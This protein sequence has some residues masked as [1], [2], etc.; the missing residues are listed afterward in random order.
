MVHSRS[1]VH[2]LRV[3]TGIATLVSVFFLM[4][5]PAAGQATTGTIRGIIKDTSGAVLPGVTVTVTGPALQVPSLVSVSD[6]KGEFRVSP[7]PPGV[8]SVSFELSGFQP[9]K[10]DNVRLALGFTATL[11]Q[12]MGVG[13]LAESVTVSGQSPL[14]DVT[15]PAT[16]VDMSAESLEILPT[17]RDGLKA[18]MGTM[19]GVRTNL[20][21][22]ASSL[23]DTVVFRSFGQDG[24]SWQML[25]GIMFS[26]PNT[27]GA[28]GSHIDFNALDSTRVQTVGSAAEM[29]RRGVM[30]DAVMKSGGNAFHGDAT[31]YGSGGS[32]ESSNLSSELKDF[33]LRNP[34]SLHKL[35]D[36]GATLGGRVVRDKLWFF[37]SVRRTG[38]DRDLL[39]A[40]DEN[41]IPMQNNRRL[42]YWSLKLS[43]QMNQSNRLSGFYHD[44]AEL[45][46][47]GGS[48]FV[49]REGREVYEGP[50]AL[51]GGSWQFVKGTSLVASLQ[52][53]TFYQKA[54]YFAEPSYENLRA[55]NPDTA[56][57]HQI[58]TLDTFTS[59]RTGDVTSDGRWLHRYRYPTKGTISYYKPDLLAGSHQFKS[60]FDLIE[61]GFHDRWRDKPAGNYDLRFNNGTPTQIISYNVPVTPLN[62]GTYFGTY[63]QDS[64]TVGSRLTLNLGVRW[65]RET[66]SAPAQC[67]EAT[68]FSAHACYPEISLA[69]WTTTLPRL[70]A[71]YD[72]FGDGT[73]VVK[74]GFGRFANL[75]DLSPELTRVAKNNRQ[76]ITWTWH[77]LNNDKMYQP[78]EVNLDPN[79]PDFRSISGVTNTAPNPDEP[80][81]KSDEWSLTVE[82]Q[83]PRNWAVRATGVYATN[84]DLRRLAEP[85]RPRS[86]Y[87]IPITNPNPGFDGVVGTADDPGTSVTYWEYPAELNGIAFAGTTIVPAVGRQHYKSIELAGTRRISGGWQA[88][89]SFTATK[90]DVPF[91]DEQADNPNTEIN[92]YNT[93][94]ETTSKLS[95]GYT[96]PFDVIVSA[97]YERRSGT[98]QAPNAVFSGGKTIN[99]I[100]INTDPIGTISLPATNLWNMRF[101]K[102]FGLG[103]GHSVEGRFDFFNI[104]NANFVTSQ[105]TREGPS[106]LVPSGIILPRIL[107]MGVTYTF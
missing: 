89:A 42:P 65:S 69:T 4:S 54:W 68:D 75:R 94:W 104:F 5:S 77:D 49:G 39:D 24:Q 66:A 43:Y 67:H 15:N 10:R 46:H 90:D 51:W 80:Q 14:V 21:V 72:L 27:G 63:F 102:R 31:Y 36:Y 106:F 7:L 97:T 28:N 92:T 2:A 33:G 62:Y 105:S 11:D 13:A 101:A 85:L 87:S 20:D 55:G 18:F 47:R 35:W 44:A 34:P 12:E 58:S 41:G 17:N 84:F 91:V 74:G 1:G 70:H 71:A 60:G 95:G 52:A 50:L 73:T 83:L 93:T 9:V 8:F 86:A 32:L 88:A 82:R 45:E 103:S 29:P 78:G 22:G 16:S 96:L 79:G 38:F 61:S 23:S 19:P 57:V 40:F 76:M 107:Q 3:A 64:W 25:E 56:A 37:G 100:A 26:T 48:R 81:P 99:N 30:L 59:I 53:G 6:A 98:P